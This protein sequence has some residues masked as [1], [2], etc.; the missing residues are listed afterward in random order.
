MPGYDG[1]GPTGRG[2]NGRGIGPC[3]RGMRG[4]KRGFFGFGR[5]GGFGRGFWPFRWRGVNPVEDEKTQLDSEK[6]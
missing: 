2:P 1:T 5:R 4:T 6:E 3:S